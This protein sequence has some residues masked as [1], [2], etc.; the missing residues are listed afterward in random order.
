LYIIKGSV[1]R[2]RLNA[3]AFV[4]RL[5]LDPLNPGRLLHRRV[6]RDEH[7]PIAPAKL[8]DRLDGRAEPVRLL[9]L[10]SANRQGISH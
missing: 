2:L 7:H 10:L 3:S 4:P 6:E 9:D 1:D 8:L 5:L